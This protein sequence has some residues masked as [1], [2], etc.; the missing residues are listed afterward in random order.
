[1]QRRTFLAVIPAAVAGTAFRVPAMAEEV[2]PVYNLVGTF[3][4]WNVIVDAYARKTGVRPTLGLRSGSSPALVALKLETR[5]PQASAAYWSLDIAV[6]AK[7]EG[8]TAPYFPQGIDV[9]PTNLKDKDGH[10]WAIASTNVIIGVNDKVLAERG[11]KPPASFADL[12]KPEYKGLAA[13][14]DPTWSGTAS[15]FM[16]GINFVLGGTKTDFRPGMRWLKAFAANGQQFRSE[17]VSPRL[18]LGDAAITVDAEGGILT[19][20]A[21]GA[22]VSAVVPAEGVVSAALGMSLAKGGPKRAE[23]E[24]F[25]DWLLGAEAQRLIAEGYFRPVRED[26]IPAQV[27]QGLPRIDNLVSLDIPH[28]ATT[29]ATLKRAFVEIVMRDGDV[30]RVLGRHGLAG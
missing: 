6:D 21:K 4:N 15:V 19:P 20:R 30:D 22:P 14:M 23:A 29:V 7:K 27:A 25:M 18:A 26:A 2:L 24:A 8:V 3:M 28:Q 17:L 9:V 5:H 12:L 11:V 1:M 16:Y 10:W 13:C